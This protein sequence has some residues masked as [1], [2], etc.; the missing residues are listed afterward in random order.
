M[1]IRFFELCLNVQDTHRKRRDAIP[2]P[3]FEW[4]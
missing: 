1:M 2:L 4:S 3:F